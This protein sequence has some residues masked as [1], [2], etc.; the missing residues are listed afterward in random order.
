MFAGMLILFGFGYLR[1]TA[2]CQGMFLP[3]KYISF[4]FIFVFGRGV[5]CVKLN[6]VLTSG[7]FP[8]F[9]LFINT[10]MDVFSFREFLAI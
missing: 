4:I 10:I 6:D 9:R 3:L 8:S 5:G 7:F 2:L 1:R